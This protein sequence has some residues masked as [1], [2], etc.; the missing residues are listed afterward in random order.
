MGEGDDEG[1][2]ALGTKIDENV[3]KFIYFHLWNFCCCDVDLWSHIK[4]GFLL[5]RWNATKRN[6]NKS[7]WPASKFN[8]HN[9]CVTVREKG[10]LPILPPSAFVG[11]KSLGNASKVRGNFAGCLFS[12]FSISLEAH[13]STHTY[14]ITS[15]TR[16][17]GNGEPWG[18]HWLP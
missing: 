8:K 11:Q 18:Q 13:M 4:F 10:I 3:M 14:P 1:K 6:A 7:F 2:R 12:Q 16:K 17:N 5:L 9:A 15:A